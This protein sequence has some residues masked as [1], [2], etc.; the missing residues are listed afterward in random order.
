MLKICS[1]KYAN[2]CKYMHIESYANIYLND[3]EHIR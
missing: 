1:G 3:I 2:I